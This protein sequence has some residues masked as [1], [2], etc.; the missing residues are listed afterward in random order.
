MLHVQAVVMAHH[1]YSGTSIT[2]SHGSLESGCSSIVEGQPAEEGAAACALHSLT[3][4][5]PAQ[6]YKSLL[7]SGTGVLP[8][9]VKTLESRSVAVEYATSRALINLAKVP[10]NQQEIISSL[11]EQ[12]MVRALSCPV[13]PA[14]PPPFLRVLA[15]LPFDAAHASG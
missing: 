4:G 3:D 8:A 1:I 7:C 12:M 11:L 9:L 14:P 5:M 6:Q 15:G 2:P 13:P 10:G